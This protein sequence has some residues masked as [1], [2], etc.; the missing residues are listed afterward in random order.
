MLDTRG[1]ASIIE[2]EVGPMAEANGGRRRAKALRTIEG[3]LSF[4]EDE[5]NSDRF[6]RDRRIALYGKITMAAELG[7]ISYREWEAYYG[8]LRALTEREGG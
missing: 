6:D 4:M 2:S 7:A 3:T 1:N 5:A 8:R